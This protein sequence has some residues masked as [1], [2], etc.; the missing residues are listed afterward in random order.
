MAQTHS[1]RAQEV[2]RR[3]FLVFPDSQ[4]KINQ[5]SPTSGKDLSQWPRWRMIEADTWAGLGERK[6][7]YSWHHN[8]FI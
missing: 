8:A 1:A 3:G 5:P 7:G 2:E 4:G 6:E